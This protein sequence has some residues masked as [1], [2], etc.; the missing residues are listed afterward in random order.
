VRVRASTAAAVVGGRLHGPDLEFDGASVDSRTVRPGALFVPVVAE[1]D[2]H[3]FIDDARGSG[4]PVYLTARPPGPGT[5]VLVDDT[6]AALWALGAHARGLLPDRVVGI[7][8]SVGKTT[9]KDLSAGALGA[10]LRTHATPASFNNE[11]GVP[12]TLLGAPEGVEAV[13]VEMGARHPGDIARL[14]PLVRPSIGVITAIGSAHLEHLGGADGVRREKGSLVESLPSTGH[15]ILNDRDCGADVR[16][17][18]DAT[19]VTFGSSG[20]DVRSTVVGRTDDLRPTVRIDSPWGSGEVTLAVRG[21]HQAV[22]A[23]A[24]VAV[25]VCAGVPFDQAMA[26][27]AT[28]AGSAGRAE[29][30]IAPSGL[31]V[32]DDTYN[33]NPDSMAAA[34]R[35]LAE[36]DAPRR[37]AVLGEMAELGS[38]GAGAHRSI[39]ALAD[40]L[41]IEI[42]SVGVPA[43]GGTLVDDQDEALRLV[44]ELP[45]DTVVLVK[46]SRTVGLERLTARLRSGEVAV[47]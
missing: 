37:V 1:R 21:D 23:A 33:A 3:D 27:V 11:L 39:A 17:R 8:G 12:L 13:V 25:A 36:A 26:G 7:T 5:A 16:A 18:T 19:V 15:A 46:A 9:V 28:A 2:G 35:T 6:S 32:L 24:A 44:E 47:R 40:A 34:M 22:N 10:G 14:C 4:S 41:G 42:V 29:F 38:A 20:A 45:V 30:W 31:R 43:Y